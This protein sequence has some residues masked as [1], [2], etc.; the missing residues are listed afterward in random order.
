MDA[1]YT[2]RTYTDVSTHYKGT[3]ELEGAGTGG[4]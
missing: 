4:V 2:Y 1:Q 3:P